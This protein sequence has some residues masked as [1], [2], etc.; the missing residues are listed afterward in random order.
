MV[1]FSSFCATFFFLSQMDIVITDQAVRKNFSDCM[2]L[3]CSNNKRKYIV[4]IIYIICVNNLMCCLKLL[5]KYCLL[6]ETGSKHLLLPQRWMSH[7]LTF[8]YVSKCVYTCIKIIN[9]IENLILFHAE[10]M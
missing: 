8:H 4:H 7:H 2:E 9:Q 1:L 5:S 6:F 10:G 3:S